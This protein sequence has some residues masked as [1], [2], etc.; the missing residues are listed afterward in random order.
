M[1]QIGKGFAGAF[2]LCSTLNL[3]R[4][5]KTAYKNQDAKLLKVVQEVAEESMIK[6]ATEIVDKNKIYHPILFLLNA[7]SSKKE[8]VSGP[9]SLKEINQAELWLIKLVQKAEF[10]KEIKN[11][12]RGEPVYRSIK[13]PDETLVSYFNDEHI[14]W[15]FIPP[16][17]TNFGG[18]WESRVKSFKTHLKRVAGN[19][20]LTLEEFITL[21]AEIEVVLNSRSLSPLSSDFH[22]FET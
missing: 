16:R 7:R 5:T 14:D 22:D 3:P 6:A 8:R 4:L 12:L 21:L 9:L 11:I 2:K 17:S 13:S 19:S 20:N 15:N 10:S 18:L 1:W